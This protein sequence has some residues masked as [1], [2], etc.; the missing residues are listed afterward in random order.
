MLAWEFPPAAGLRSRVN[1]KKNEEETAEYRKHKAEKILFHADV[2][3][4]PDF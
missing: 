1:S 3:R 2:V 4:R